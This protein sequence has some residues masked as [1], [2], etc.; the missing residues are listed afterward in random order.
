[1]FI[2]VINSGISVRPLNEGKVGVV[3]EN[4]ARGISTDFE[5]SGHSRKILGR[6]AIIKQ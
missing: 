2:V 1:M 4:E 3:L 6:V 5:F